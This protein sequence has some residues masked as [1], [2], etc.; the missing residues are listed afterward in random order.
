MAWHNCC[1]DG[2]KFRFK[3]SEKPLIGKDTCIHNVR[4]K[5]ESQSNSKSKSNHINPFLCST[6]VSGEAT[7]HERLVKGS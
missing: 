5:A 4:L 2:K 3:G 6:Y 7:R 1:A